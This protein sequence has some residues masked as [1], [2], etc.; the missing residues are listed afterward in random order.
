MW[1]TETRPHVRPESVVSFPVTLATPESQTSSGSSSRTSPG[2]RYAAALGWVAIAIA[3]LVLVGWAFDITALTKVIPAA[4]AMKPNTAV[5]IL[6]LAASLILSAVREP[7][8]RASPDQVRRTRA[9]ALV[10]LAVGT[11]TVIEYLTGANLGLDLLLFKDALIAQGGP[12]P[13]RISPA[14]SACLALLSIAM[15]L[16]D[17]RSARLRW[18]GQWPALASIIIAFIAVLGYLYGAEQ[19]N[20]VKPFATVALHTALLTV[21]LGC[22]ILVVRPDR[23]IASEIFSM[24]HG[25]LM[26][27][28]VLPI[29]VFMPMIIGWVR[30]QGERAGW[31]ETEVGLALFAA[32]NIAV[33]AAVIWFAARALNRI[34]ADRRGADFQRLS[35]LREAETR[36]RALVEASAQIVWTTNAQGEPHDSPSLRAFTGQTLEQLRIEGF[37]KVVHPDDVGRIDAIWQHAIRHR[38]AFE[39]ELRMRQSNREWRWMSVRAVPITVTA[40]SDVA[41]VG[42]NH[43][44][45]ERKLGQALAEGQKQVLELIARGAPLAETLDALARVIEEQSD[46]MYCSILLLDPDGKHLRH[47]AAPRLPPSYTEA[48]D[49]APIGPAVGSCGTAAFTRR[50]VYVEDIAVDPLWA[51]YKQLALPHGLRACWSTPILDASGRVLGTFA[52]YYLRPGLPTERHL[53]LID[54]ATHTAAICL[55]RHNQVQALRDSESRFRQLAESLPQLVWTCNEEG[56][57]DYLSQQWLD[58]TGIPAIAQLG[59]GWHQLLHPVDRDSIAIA[60][61]AAISRGTEFRGEFRLRRHDGTYRWFDTR[62]VPLQDPSGRTVKWIG[63]NTDIDDR[64][65]FEET[66]LRSQKLEALGTLAGGI[67]HDFN[68]MLLVILGNAQLA[69]ELLD[70]DNAVQE[71]LVEITHAS[72]RAAD[73]VRRILSFSRPQKA[74]HKVIR[75][76]PVVEEALKFARAALPAMVEIRA[77]VAAHVPPVA[78]DATQIHQIVLNLATNSA[79]AIGGRGGLIEIELTTLDIDA[80]AKAGVLDPDVGQLAPGRYARLTVRDD[81]SGISPEVAERI[82]DPFFTTKP[83]G[84]GTGLGLSIVHGIMSSSGGAVTVQ[85]D[86]GKGTAF[87]L[88]FPAAE[89]GAPSAATGTHATLARGFGQHVLLIDDEDALVRLGTLNLTRQGFRVTGCTEA[90][91]ALREFHR[92]PDAFDAVVTDLSMPGMTGFDCAREML[93]LRPDLPIVLTSGYIRPED[94]AQALSL[95]IRAVCSKPTALNE[96][97]EILRGVLPQSG[98]GIGPHAGA[99]ERPGERLT[100]SAVP[101]PVAGGS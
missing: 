40:E 49:G 90:V 91:A 42:M 93:A 92:D 60:W 53:R 50:A 88:Y 51:D 87:H 62:A 68:N 86:L 23:S 100:T 58:F 44:I 15:L 5:A 75:L 80:G 22:A 27:R 66:Q 83:V 101:A 64:K 19:L 71:H 65:R 29:A 77:T 43:D 57:C 94:E 3:A 39:G 81:G 24:H 79:H 52:I 6:F 48:I 78:A 54:L 73:L 97:G 47:G 1:D 69:H 13:G 56:L 26:I 17:V 20:H 38:T 82:F 2:P 96:L 10:P 36:W 45:T 84:Q 8:Y 32:A 37:R 31:Y 16:L 12:N 72:E 55:S 41:W 35:A 18:L 67:A 28:R 63:S 61:R 46:E 34:D 59:Q 9:L 21:M 14:T 70:K 74:R 7:P 76:G 11:L 25:G 98:P 85:S 89:E 33:F 95:G 30:M 99:P 4:A